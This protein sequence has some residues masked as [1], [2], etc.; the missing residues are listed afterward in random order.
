MLASLKN[1]SIFQTDDAGVE[2]GDV[3]DNPPCCDEEEDGSVNGELDEEVDDAFANVLAD[4]D[5]QGSNEAHGSAN[6][7]GH[8][9]S[10]YAGPENALTS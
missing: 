6:G 8:E 1:G 10:G 9:D 5:P 3:D 7:A 2:K 4:D